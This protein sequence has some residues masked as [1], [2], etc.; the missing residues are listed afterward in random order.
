LSW[1]VEPVLALNQADNDR[2]FR[3]AIDCARQNDLVVR[4]DRV[5]IVAGMPITEHTNSLKVFT[6][7]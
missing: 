1:G 5:V 3:H 4:G 6:V 2:L 7:E